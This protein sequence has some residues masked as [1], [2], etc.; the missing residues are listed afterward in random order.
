MWSEP[1]K[2]EQWDSTWESML[3]QSET[4]IGK[5]T[6]QATLSPSDFAACGKCIVWMVHNNWS[7]GSCNGLKRT[8]FLW[9]EREKCLKYYSIS[10]SVLK[11]S[12]YPARVLHVV[13]AY[14]NIP[15]SSKLFPFQGYGY[16]LYGQFCPNLVTAKLLGYGKYKTIWS[17]WFPFLA[18]GLP[19]GNKRQQWK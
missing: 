18:C 3:R 5:E 13:C 4:K 7:Y 10:N 9:R 2:W 14:E 12:I 1:D 17:T 15:W 11:V 19:D 6:C 16:H 8:L